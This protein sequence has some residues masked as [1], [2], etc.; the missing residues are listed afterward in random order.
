VSF[1]VGFSGVEAGDLA[2]AFRA[3]SVPQVRADAF[4]R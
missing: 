1:V 3:K 2:R 4:R